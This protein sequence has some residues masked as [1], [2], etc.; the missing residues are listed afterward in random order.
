MKRFWALR[1]ECVF[2]CPFHRNRMVQSLRHVD[3]QPSPRIVEVSPEKLLFPK[4]VGQ[5]SPGSI[6]HLPSVSWMAH[7]LE[8]RKFSG[9]KSR[10]QILSESMG[11]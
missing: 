4:Q 11:G 8:M 1:V 7:F 3:A 6:S 10:W 2:V 9:F 5:M